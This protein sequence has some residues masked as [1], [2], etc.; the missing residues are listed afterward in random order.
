MFALSFFYADD[1]SNI[2]SSPQTISATVSSS[3][4]ASQGRMGVTEDHPGNNNSN[5][6]NKTNLCLSIRTIII[7][8]III[9]II[10]IIIMI[11]MILSISNY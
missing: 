1:F 11:T 3:C 8:I 9:I 2:Q 5:N 7:I 4:Q 10:T 6:N